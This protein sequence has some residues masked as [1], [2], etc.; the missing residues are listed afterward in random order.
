MIKRGAISSHGYPS[1]PNSPVLMVDSSRIFSSLSRTESIR[2]TARAGKVDE[3]QSITY[4]DDSVIM[5]C[6]LSVND[7]KGMCNPVQRDI[8]YLSFLFF[9]FFFLFYH[10]LIF[11]F[12]F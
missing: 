2:K 1:Y 10:I 12:L 5:I 9:F 11:F 3:D 6:F 8:I 4:P 7:P